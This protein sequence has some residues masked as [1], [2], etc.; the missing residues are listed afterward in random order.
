MSRRK[1]LKRLSEKENAILHTD[2]IHYGHAHGI[3]WMELLDTYVPAEVPSDVEKDLLIV[4]NLTDRTTRNPSRIWAA[5][6]GLSLL[7][8]GRF[9]DWKLR[10]LMVLPPA[11]ADL[12]LPRSVR[13]RRKVAIMNEA[14]SRKSFIVAETDNAEFLIP[15]GFELL[16]K[17]AALVAQRTAENKIVVPRSRRRS[18]PESYSE[19]TA[20]LRSES[21]PVKYPIFAGDTFKEFMEKK[22]LYEESLRNLD[23][24]DGQASTEAESAKASQLKQDFTRA[25]AA[26][27]HM[28][29]ASDA[30]IDLA[31]QQMQI[32]SL[33]AE[34]VKAKMDPNT[35]C[36][37]LERLNS[38]LTN[39]RKQFADMSSEARFH[40]ARKLP[41]MVN[42]YRLALGTS[43]D[44]K[45]SKL[46]WDQRPYE[47]LYI[48]PEEVSPKGQGC[49]VVYIEPESSATLFEKFALKDAHARHDEAVEIALSVVGTFG[50]RAKETIAM[51][52]D[53]LFPGQSTADI[54]K[55][56]P[57]LFDWIPRQLR[58]ESAAEGDPPKTKS[59]HDDTAHVAP[60]SPSPSPSPSFSSSSSSSFYDEFEYLPDQVTL[61][62]LPV[63]AILGLLKAYLNTPQSKTF[64]QV[65]R[66]LG[67]SATL[68][69]LR[70][71]NSKDR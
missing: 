11:E 61:Q 27:V 68:F 26:L 63:D 15:R 49:S 14:Y 41:N 51:M 12:I 57:E 5:L 44:I 66:S 22:T 55:L 43:G 46:L 13:N 48:R 39:L 3:G 56:V 65:N 36:S 2:K 24:K 10:T 69:A 20:S 9:A 47:P 70:S 16:K 40:A 60:S 71:W 37:N 31:K 42:D 8:R 1:L 54:I 18:L 52:F 30:A 64:L 50:V 58:T 45:D 29:K 67:G 62:C 59:T 34:V 35:E 53:K 4:A 28:A 6:V 38:R 32:V 33:E 25:R 23:A 7:N 19:I 21:H 17:S